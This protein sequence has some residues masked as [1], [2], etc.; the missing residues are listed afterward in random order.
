MRYITQHVRPDLCPSSNEL[1]L[2]SA[3]CCRATTTRYD[4]SSKRAPPLY[5]HLD[6]A[7]ASRSLAYGVTGHREQSRAVP[8]N[9]GPCAHRD[10][11]SR[12]A[13]L[14]DSILR[15][16]ISSARPSSSSAMCDPFLG[17]FSRAARGIRD[18]LRTSFAEVV[19]TVGK[20]SLP[21]AVRRTAALGRHFAKSTSAPSATKRPFSSSTT[22]MASDEEVSNPKWR[23]L[24][25][26]SVSKKC[27]LRP[28]CV[29]AT[30]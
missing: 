17:A 24:L 5:S 30:D 10:S 13:E 27:E 20:V 25:E 23:Q 4:R 22:S 26:E 3:F 7:F 14:C 12:L 2:T 16:M 6:V 29:P 21:Q 9:P 1:P 11:R 28:A 19:E 8:G 18:A 15:S